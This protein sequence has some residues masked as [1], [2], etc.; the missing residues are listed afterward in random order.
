MQNSTISTTG[1][2][3]DVLVTVNSSRTRS[4]AFG[5]VN[6]SHIVQ[7]D[8]NKDVL[9]TVAV[10]DGLDSSPTTA[11]VTSGGNE[12]RTELLTDGT[13]EMYWN[14]VKVN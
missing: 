9:S 3:I 10:V 6:E 5:E 11:T 4:F 8:G 13:I 14:N 7:V 12:A 2:Q 1:N